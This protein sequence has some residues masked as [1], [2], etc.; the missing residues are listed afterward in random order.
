MINV[1]EDYLSLGYH[2]EPPGEAAGEDFLLDRIKPES[3]V[4]VIF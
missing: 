4:H 3:F 2:F 1:L